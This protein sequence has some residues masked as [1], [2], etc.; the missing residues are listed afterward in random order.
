M[1]GWTIICGNGSKSV[2]ISSLFE[3]FVRYIGLS[4]PRVKICQGH[5]GH[6]VFQRVI[7]V[8]FAEKLGKLF[9]SRP[10]WLFVLE[11]GEGELTDVNVEDCI[12]FVR[13]V[14]FP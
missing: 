1:I 5:Q 11:D 12:Q 14:R 8:P 2:Q 3:L 4:A 13:L 6:V 9:A 10:R 7:L